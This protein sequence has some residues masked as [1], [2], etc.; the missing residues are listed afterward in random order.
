MRVL[1]AVMCGVLLLA[2]GAS[3]A[4]SATERG[5]DAG[6]VL[7]AAAV[8]QSGFNA[9]LALSA[10]IDGMT[11]DSATT[12]GLLPAFHAGE[13]LE[14]T[15]DL[16]WLRIAS[17]AEVFF[18]PLALRSLSIGGE[19]NIVSASPRTAPLRHVGVSVGAALVWFPFG[20]LGIEP[21][22]LAEL[23]TT[24]FTYAL[25][26]RLS[27]LLH[28]DVDASYSLTTNQEPLNPPGGKGQG[29][30]VAPE[31]KSARKPKLTITAGVAMSVPVSGTGRFGL[32]VGLGV[33]ASFLPRKDPEAAAVDQTPEAPESPALVEPATPDANE[34]LY[35]GYDLCH[36]EKAWSATALVTAET[37][38]STWLPGKNWRMKAVERGK[39]KALEMAQPQ[40]ERMKRDMDAKAAEL[41]EFCSEGCDASITRTGPTWP[42]RFEVVEYIPGRLDVSAIFSCDVTVECR[43]P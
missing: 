11:F 43:A 13:T 20:G 5:T 9:E 7:W 1:H 28:L 2:V 16:G 15:Y 27:D 35:A 22:V 41:E 39:E 14:G 32:D 10:T 17:A 29:S 38:Y 36:K 31:R 25:R 42:P 34:D 3:F 23:E 24:R 8:P 6:I 19:V 37:K 18:A 21:N 4:E 26:G 33:C 12:L 30:V 40:L